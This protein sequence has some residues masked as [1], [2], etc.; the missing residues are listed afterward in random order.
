MLIILIVRYIIIG[1]S[2]NVIITESMSCLPLPLSLFISLSFTHV[3]AVEFSP[4]FP[5]KRYRFSV[6][7]LPTPSF[8]SL[9]L[10]LCVCVHLKL[11]KT[12]VVSWILCVAYFTLHW[13]RI[14]AHNRSFDALL[15]YAS[16]II[17]TNI[18]LSCCID[19]FLCAQD[20]RAGMAQRKRVAVF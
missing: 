14:I 4:P 12:I 13:I 3:H 16:W 8:L 9:T 1:I 6:Y 10:S 17:Y 5:P 20:T 11:G 18:L 19:T 15:R 7:F 2:I